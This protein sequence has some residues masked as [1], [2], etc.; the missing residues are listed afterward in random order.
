M[1][2]SNETD[3]T[4]IDRTIELWQPRVVREL[5]REDARQMILNATKFFSVLGEW[6]RADSAGA[7]ARNDIHRE[8]REVCHDS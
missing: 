3:E 6:A 8:D 1:T 4:L 5:S 2:L 7:D